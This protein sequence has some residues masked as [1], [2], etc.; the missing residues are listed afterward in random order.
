M[1]LSQERR[2]AVF[3][4]AILAIILALT[5][6][7]VRS[8]RTDPVSETLKR[9]SVVKMLIVLNDGEG[10]ALTTDILAFYPASRQGALF[11]IL[12]NTGA[13]YQSLL[14]SDGQQGR[15]DRIDAVYR[16]RGMETYV[17]EVAKFTGI[18]IPFSMEITLD[19]LGLLTDLLG[20]MKAFP[21]GLHRCGWRPLA[22]AERG[23][24]P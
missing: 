4:L 14:R 24:H 11:N 23:G 20:G 16:E 8:L 21:G 12:G 6:F 7:I 2:S 5:V 1:D 22:A 10:N 18:S 3:L 15:T 19:G 9:D 13:I 17:S